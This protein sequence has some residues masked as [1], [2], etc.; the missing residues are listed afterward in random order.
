MA[1]GLD[2]I[3]E[4]LSKHPR[5]IIA[6]DF[7]IAVQRVKG[8]TRKFRN[9]E[10]S[11]SSQAENL[12]ISLRILHR[13]RPGRAVTTAR[14]RESLGLLVENAF[15]AAQL[16]SP[17]PWF[18]FPIWKNVRFERTPPTP[19]A[20]DTLFE[21]LG[22]GFEHFEESYETS[23]VETMLQ[24]KTER[25]GLTHSREVHGLSYSLLHQDD[26]D[27]AMVRDERS[28]SRPLTERADW[29]AALARLSLRL[30]KAAPLKASGRSPAILTSPVMVAVM[31]RLVP[32]F[33]AD[34]A[35]CGR[36]FF[37]VEVGQPMFAPVI[38]I[39][40]HGQFPE[41]PHSAPFDMEG[42]LTQ[43]TTLIDRGVF[44][45]LLYDTYCATRE[46]RL[47]TGNFLRPP[48]AAHPRI[49]ASNFYLR[50]GDQSLSE[51]IH[52]M[53]RGVVV[54][55]LDSL[56]SLGGADTTC[57]LRGKGWRVAEGRCVEPVKNIVLKFDIFELFQRAV[58][59][60]NDL[61]FYG[62][63]GSPSIF[64]EEIPLS[65]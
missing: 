50:P 39:C 41:A 4:I 8:A 42:S 43:E 58:S 32:G 17:D 20:Y 26:D 46:N 53:G 37:P 62:P 59:V 28:L 25:F 23:Y 2:Q 13:K 16:S 10:L 30:R 1:A 56:E 44:K 15:Q 55:T 11:H 33:Y 21:N 35:Q 6:D 27:F 63:H 7:E 47:S 57:I 65:S 61:R 14:T 52:A 24:R 45:D 22:G 48:Q 38:S 51:L 49:A 40:D 12:W 3:I 19:T 64:F 60:G 18:R 36:T 9:G 34:A 29:L 5:L 54:E 31:R